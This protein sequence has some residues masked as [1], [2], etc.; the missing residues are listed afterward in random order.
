M[1]PDAD[2]VKQDQDFQYKMAQ[3]ASDEQRSRRVHT[4]ERVTNIC[5]AMGIVLGLA[6]VAA[7]IYFVQR[8]FG[9]RDH[10]S[11]RMRREVQQTCVA[12]GGTWT[13]IGGGSEV[14]VHIGGSSDG[15]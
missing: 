15:R 9:Q 1:N 7:L 5:V 11:E 2:W 8:D 3:L 4:T 6:T 12:G 10:E 14:C 13:S